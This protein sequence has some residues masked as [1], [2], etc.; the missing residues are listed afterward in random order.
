[1]PG[2]LWCTDNGYG[3]CPHYKNKTDV[4]R[5][6]LANE[7]VT[8]L[9]VRMAQVSLEYGYDYL[10]LA[11][12]SAT[13]SPFAS[14]TGLS[15]FT[16]QTYNVPSGYSMQ[17]NPLWAHFTTDSSVRA[18]GFTMDNVVASCSS[19]SGFMSNVTYVD[20]H[21]Q[22]VT[23]VLLATHDVV[24][25]KVYKTT[26]SNGYLRFALWGPSS[27]AD[28]DLYVRCG[29]KPTISSWDYRGNGGSTQEFIETSQGYCSSGTIY[30]AVHSYGGAGRWDFL[31]SE[32]Y[33]PCEPLRVG[34]DWTPT[35]IER[36]QL[37]ETARIGA[38]YFYGATDG[39]YCLKTPEIFENSRIDC[40]Q[41]RCVVTFS[42]AS[43]SYCC[44]HEQTGGTC[45]SDANCG[46]DETCDQGVCKNRTGPVHI[47]ISNHGQPTQVAHELMHKYWGSAAGDQY[48]GSGSLARCGHSIQASPLFLDNCT[49]LN[50]GIEH[51]PNTTAMPPPA[52]W[53]DAYSQG[54]VPYSKYY[55]PNWYSFG[56]FERIP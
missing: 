10:Y 56:D 37:E 48:A 36:A 15:S 16:T 33:A 32:G 2:W 5:I 39:T 45:Q 55:T 38:R 9:Q 30:V 12:R 40:G 14:I 34:I 23:G 8:R 20:P 28:F 7:Y 41:N 22:D 6:V 44:I 53:A 49:S 4:A 19:S 21:N 25:L 13:F 31:F 1:M 46:T 26:S 43:G 35:T 3:T 51:D 17:S 50:H 54:I 42:K 52:S 18:A 47:G 11:P 24:H 27:G 29:A